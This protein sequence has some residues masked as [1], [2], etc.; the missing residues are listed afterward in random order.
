MAAFNRSAIATFVE[1]TSRFL[2]LGSLPEDHGAQSVYECLIEVTAVLPD[3]L[4]R[5]LTWDQGRE[6]ALWPK[7]QL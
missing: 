7:L 6:M 3:V 4:R 2:L 5:S 1:W